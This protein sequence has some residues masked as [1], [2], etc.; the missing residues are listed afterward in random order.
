MIDN[1]ELTLKQDIDEF[2]QW[3]L[4]TGYSF[5]TYDIYRSELNHFFLFIIRKQIGWND[6][7]TLDTLK[8]F[9]ECRKSVTAPA[10]RKLFRYLLNKKESIS[11]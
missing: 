2:L 5:G 1:P 9:Q 8:D 3:M 4:S 10:V 7:F 6:I 11:L